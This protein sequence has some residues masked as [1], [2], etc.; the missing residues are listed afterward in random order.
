M[1][2]RIG[3]AL[4]WRQPLMVGCVEPGCR[5]KEPDVADVGQARGKSGAQRVVAGQRVLFGQPGL[6]GYDTS[7]LGGTVMRFSMRTQ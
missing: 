3:R 2:L 4:V 7:P 1:G 5:L 6:R